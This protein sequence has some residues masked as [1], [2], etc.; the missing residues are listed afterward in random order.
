MHTNIAD[1][2][3]DDSDFVEYIQGGR[4][5]HLKKVIEAEPEQ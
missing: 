4:I 5:I 1:D 3:V 2:I